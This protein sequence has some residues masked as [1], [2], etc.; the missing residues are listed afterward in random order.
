MCADETPG[1]T[2][3]YIGSHGAYTIPSNL[4][5]KLDYTHA[6]ACACSWSHRQARGRDSGKIEGATGQLL[7]GGQRSLRVEIHGPG[8]GH[9]GAVCDADARR[10]VA[11][12]VVASLLLGARVE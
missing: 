12:H 6:C 9:F 10:S 7:A 4:T 8:G 5:I 3:S 11:P 1:E 2:M